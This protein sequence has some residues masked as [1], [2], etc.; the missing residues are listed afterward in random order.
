LNSFYVDQPNLVY[1]SADL[2]IRRINFYSISL[3]QIDFFFF[4]C[5]KLPSNTDARIGVRRNPKT[6]IK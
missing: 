5:P 3:D 6:Q 4:R 1:P 2:I